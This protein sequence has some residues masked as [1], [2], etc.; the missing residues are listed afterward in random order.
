MRLGGNAEQVV[1]LS[2]FK[3]G[4]PIKLAQGI[5]FVTFGGL[6]TG[7]KGTKKSRVEQIIDWVGEDFDRSEERRVGKEC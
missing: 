6:R 3:L 7:A 4:E 2:K 5:L 1:A